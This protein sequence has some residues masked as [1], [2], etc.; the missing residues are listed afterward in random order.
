MPSLINVE[1]PKI[2]EQSKELLEKASLSSKTNQNCSLLEESFETPRANQHP[3]DQ[4]FQNTPSCSKAKT[5]VLPPHTSL[6]TT[7]S[8][9][10]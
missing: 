5:T 4:E 2:L 8:G 1:V 3:S 10:S 6:K 7:R 9:G